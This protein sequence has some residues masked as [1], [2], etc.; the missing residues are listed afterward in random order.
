MNWINLPDH[1]TLPYKLLSHCRTLETQCEQYQKLRK[2]V[3][4]RSQQSMQ[5]QPLHPP[6]TI[7]PSTPSSSVE[8]AVTITTKETA[9]YM[10]R[11][12]KTLARKATSPACAENQEGSP[13]VEPNPQHYREW[14]RMHYHSKNNTTATRGMGQASGDTAVGVAEPV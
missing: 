1:S 7:M 11:T 5:L 10:A 12:T 8:N 13:K 9:Q 4:Q 3:M 6:Y 2:K 14:S